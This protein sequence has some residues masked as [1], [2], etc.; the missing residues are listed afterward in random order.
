M[1]VHKPSD[2][3][4]PES[5]KVNVESIKILDYLDTKDK[6]IR[7]K[8][9]VLPVEDGSVCGIL[10]KSKMVDKSLGIFKPKDIEFY[11]QKARPKDQ[12]ARKACYA[13]LS[14][15]NEKK[16]VIEEIPFDFRY[17]FSCY[18][19]PLCSGH[20]YSII[21]W[22]IGQAYRNW[23]W[24]YKTQELL[25]EKIRERWLTLVCSPK[26][27]VY[28]FVGNMKRFRDNFMVLGVFY[29]PQIG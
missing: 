16:Q 14:F 25:L 24:K 26:N 9:I 22:E 5:F 8:K 19:K 18:N 21:D 7:R 1:K 15:F 13:Q 10:E 6:W 12:G 4:R 3:R 11:W 2:D 23:R 28:F 27:D 20:D 29:P 17:R